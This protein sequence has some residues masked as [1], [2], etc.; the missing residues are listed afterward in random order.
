MRFISFAAAIIVILLFASSQLFS[1][2]FYVFDVDASEYPKMKAKFFAI[3]DTTQLIN[4]KKSDFSVREDGIERKITNIYCEPNQKLNNSIVLSIDISGSMRKNEKIVKETAN[5]LIMAFNMPPNEMAIQTSNSTALIVKDFSTDKQELSDAVAEIK[6]DGGNDFVEHLLNPKTGLFN[7][8]KTGKYQHVAI[9]LTDAYWTALSDEEIQEAI[10]TCKAYNITFYPVFFTPSN[11]MLSGIKS[12]L[13]EIVKK[14]GGRKFDGIIEYEN[15]LDLADSIT[16]IINNQNPC[17]I[18]WISGPGCSNLKTVAIKIKTMNITAELQYYTNQDDLP[19]LEFS[20]ASMK[21]YETPIGTTRDTTIKVTAVNGGFDIYKLVSSDPQFKMTPRTFSLYEGQSKELKVEYTPTGLINSFGKFTFTTDLCPAYY[22]TYG[23]IKDTIPDYERNPLFLTYPNGG[24]NF[25]VGSDT[26]ATWDGIP[27]DEF[28]TLDYSTNGGKN[29]EVI[30]DSA[31]GLVH[32]FTVPDRVSDSCLMRVTQKS[33]R[34]DTLLLRNS[35]LMFEEDTYGKDREQVLFWS[36][37]GDW[38][39]SNLTSS[40]VFGSVDIRNIATG[41]KRRIERSGFAKVSPDG[42]Q[43]AARKMSDIRTFEDIYLYDFPELAVIDSLEFPGRNI[44]KFDWSPDGNFM[45]IPSSD[46]LIIYDI[47]QRQAA[48]EIVCNDKIHIVK[49]SPSGN[50]LLVIFEKKNAKIINYDTGIID[51]DYLYA[52]DYIG[53][54]EWH[55][56]KDLLAVASSTP[57]GSKV[58]DIDSRQAIEQYIDAYQATW[59]PDGNYIALSTKL[60]IEIF[61]RNNITVSAFPQFGYNFEYN[62]DSK[63]SPTENKIIAGSDN[64]DFAMAYLY[65]LEHVTMFPLSDASDSLWSIVK[66]E[67]EAKDIVFGRV[68][69]NGSRDSLA[70]PF[71]SNIGSW[72]AKINSITIAG[73]DVNQFKLVSGFPPYEI[74]EGESSFA[75]FSFRPTSE[76]IKKSNI[77]IKTPFA[78]LRYKISGEAIKPKFEVVAKLI[79]FGKIKIGRTRD[80]FLVVL[81]NISSADITIDSTVM[82]GPDK[83]QF[84]ILEGGGAFVFADTHPMRIEFAPAEIGRTSGQIG[85]YYNGLG[86]PAVAVL[87]GEGVTFPIITA[88]QPNF[89]YLVCGNKTSDS[90]IIRNKG[91]MPLII[92][93]AGFSGPDDNDFK[94][95]TNLSGTKIN[96]ND[97]LVCEI[98]FQPQSPGV[99]NAE[100]II[101]SNADNDSTLIIGLSGIKDIIDMAVPV[102]EINMGAICPNNSTDKTISISNISTIPAKFDMLEIT[103]PFKIFGDNPF[104]SSFEVGE[105]RDLSIRFDGTET[106]GI[107]RQT[108]NI[109]DSCGDS[110]EI[111]FKIKVME[112]PVLYSSTND[113]GGVLLKSKKDAAL[114]LSNTGESGIDILSIKL[115]DNSGNFVINGTYSYPI[116]IP[117][118]QSFDINVTF[119]PTELK[120]YSNGIEI[121]F[122]EPCSQT[123]YLALEGSAIL[124]TVVWLPDTSGESGMENFVIPVKAKITGIAED[125]LLIGQSYSAELMFNASAFLPDDLSNVRYENNNAIVSISGGG[126][127][128]SRDT[129]TV[130]YEL[131]GS[132]LLPQNRTTPIFF[133]NF[134]WDNKHLTADTISGS[135]YNTVC[136]IDLNQILLFKPTS[137]M[138]SPNPASE[139]VNISIRTQETGKHELYLYS[140]EG[141]MVDKY[142]FNKEDSKEI[143]VYELNI[144]VLNIHSGVYRLILRTPMQALSEKLVI[145][146]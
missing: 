44:S 21:F 116:P 99:K 27:A 68:L 1:Q 37:G 4:F 141:V 80:T 102:D 111:N 77:I 74:K 46:T 58:F 88:G 28:V 23:L 90:I 112:F 137:M 133:R 103:E 24:E 48:G 91:K 94:L 132:V 138:I 128:L 135:I 97:T 51:D 98:G 100:L 50:Y 146:K 113:F 126:F 72:P 82:L 115:Q 16:A 85:F 2:I 93:N 6:I 78:N 119:I 26:I 66:P 75:E 20:P 120:D 142:Y 96:P 84:K 19:Y 136:G 70:D 122:G 25:I 106:P 143:S 105:E 125:T 36:P 59:S 139:S 32:R 134:S 49:W 14:V 87:Y 64:V 76:G 30:S 56:S 124:N 61:D 123:I 104:D 109:T 13:M 145:I 38:I 17:E 83:K 114:A 86:S 43:L 67:I 110:R 144:N 8:A 92:S 47:N 71:I 60:G 69:V 107:Y 35:K 31:S 9:L 131:E 7:V 55:N 12:S 52:E 42:F 121:E 34:K 22:R 118:G 108:I 15:A 18:E 40:S 45:A 89:K 33:A 129:A 140:S 130:I 63:W 62:H 39:I 29:W 57:Y 65:E 5:F 10:D 11:D 127:P 41:A 79:D 54:F 117:S 73:G 95:L 101:K 53:D 81:K 3:E